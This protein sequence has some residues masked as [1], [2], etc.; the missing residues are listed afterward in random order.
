MEGEAAKGIKGDD[1]QKGSCG[2]HGNEPGGS[3]TL[4]DNRSLVMRLTVSNQIIDSLS[5]NCKYP[6]GKK[7][8][9]ES[10]TT[11]TAVLGDSG[12]LKSFCTAWVGRGNAYRDEPTGKGLRSWLHPE[13]S[14]RD[15]AGAGKL[16]KWQNS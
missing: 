1:T 15:L 16:W 7:G 11:M 6:K 14:G 9:S 3:G 4:Q 12:C 8:Q 10:R 13:K 2:L 5:T